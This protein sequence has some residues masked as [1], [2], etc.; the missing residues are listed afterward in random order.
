MVHLLLDGPLCVK[1][2]QAVLGLSQVA[3][4]KH[5]AYLKRRGL[6]EVRRNGTLRVY[7]LPAARDGVLTALLRSLTECAAADPLCQGDQQRRQ[8]LA[9]AI[10]RDVT[11]DLQAVQPRRTAARVPEVTAGQGEAWPSVDDGPLLD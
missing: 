4:S 9:A 5:L 11:G 1:H 10:R 7:S 6:V 2:F 8:L 3:T